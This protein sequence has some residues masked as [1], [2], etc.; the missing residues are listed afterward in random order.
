MSPS[1]FAQSITALK[2]SVERAELAK[3]AAKTAYD[4]AISAKEEAAKKLA[5]LQ[6]LADSAKAAASDAAAAA[7]EALKIA[8]SKKTVASSAA[9]VQIAA[10]TALSRASTLSKTAD[11]AKTKTT[12]SLATAESALANAKSALDAANDAVSAKAAALEEA[13]KEHSAA[14]AAANANPRDTKLRAARQTALANQTAATK[15]A[16]SAA[17]LKRS[18]GTRYASAEKAVTAAKTAATTAAAAASSASKALETATANATTAASAASLAAK[19]AAEAASAASQATATS[20]SLASAMASAVR[21]ASAQNLQLSRISATLVSLLRRY[22]SLLAAYESALSKYRVAL[23]KV[24]GEPTDPA[25]LPFQRV[26]DFVIPDALAEKSDQGLE[27]I[28]IP[29]S[30]QYEGVRCLFIPAVIASNFK[31]EFIELKFGPHP[32][33]EK[34]KS[35]YFMEIPPPEKE[36]FNELYILSCVAKGSDGSIVSASKLV[37]RDESLNG[38]GMDPSDFSQNNPCNYSANGT[39][40]NTYFNLARP[41]LAPQNVF[42]EENRFDPPFNIVLTNSSGE[43]LHPVRDAYS[44]RK[45]FAVSQDNKL[46]VVM[47]PFA[48]PRYGCYL[49]LVKKKLGGQFDDYFIWLKSFISAYPQANV[50]E[51]AGTAGIVNYN[52]NVDAPV[53]VVFD[54]SGKAVLIGQ[55]DSGEPKVLRTMT[56]A[57]G[58]LRRYFREQDSKTMP[59][60]P[61]EKALDQ[62]KNFNA[63]LEAEIQGGNLGW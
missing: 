54:S 46:A 18:A 44:A 24:G 12:A 17:S 52:S 13:K 7:T 61:F 48:N 19:E 58:L 30:K 62:F 59:I 26:F 23:A 20:R 50:T 25:E 37:K 49:P 38:H 16:S 40:A 56:A 42:S 27:M 35:G 5:E 21:V 57:D 51:N 9:R 32:Y 45:T 60:Y 8:G 55:N 41:H 34:L 6:A 29:E 47:R 14:V 63:E 11:A 1:S 3:N 28:F 33:N 15:A 2:S 43:V 39:I 36:F 22:N 4:N 10:N 31:K 53:A